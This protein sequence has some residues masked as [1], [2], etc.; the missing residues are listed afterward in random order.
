[1]ELDEGFSINQFTKEELAT[2]VHEY[3]HFLQNITTTYGVVYFNDN[4][5]FIQLFVAEAYKYEQVIPFPIL[6][7]NCGVENAY[8]EM[9]LRSFYLGNSEHKKFII[10]IRFA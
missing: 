9:E 6:E 4:S 10:L 7:E 5:L 3:I 1:M 8:E 2:F